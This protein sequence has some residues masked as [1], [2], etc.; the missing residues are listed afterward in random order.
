MHVIQ[1]VVNL[2]PV[3]IH[4]NAELK[5]QFALG[6]LGVDLNHV[7]DTVELDDDSLEEVVHLLS[8]VCS[9]AVSDC[10]FHTTIKSS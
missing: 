10:L 1:V 6:T 7:L 8:I 9:I 3:R 2:L 4:E 5:L